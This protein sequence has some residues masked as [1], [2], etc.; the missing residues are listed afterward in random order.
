MTVFL[1]VGTFSVAVTGIV[2]AP[3]PQLK[4]MIPPAV[5]AVR[6]EANVQLAA[7]PV[8]TT[9]V[10]FEVPAGTPLAGMPV[11]HDPFGL[12]AGP[13]APAS[14]AGTAAS[15]ALASLCGLVPDSRALTSICPTGPESTA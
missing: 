6:S 10:G 12:P 2:T 15:R 8:P 13:S 3:L 4:V 11:L 9:V 7:V 1:L 5:T 14:T